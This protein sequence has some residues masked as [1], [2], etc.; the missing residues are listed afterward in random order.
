MRPFSI[1]K[2]LPFFFFL[3]I[4][5]PPRSTLF[6]Y[7]TLFRSHQFCGSAHCGL[8]GPSVV[9]RAPRRTLTPHRN[10]VRDCLLGVLPRGCPVSLALRRSELCQ[11]AAFRF[12]A[13]GR[14]L[15]A[16]RQRGAFL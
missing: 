5:R 3:M 8:Q 7:T 1:R 16:F 12:A 9:A 13:G 15:S 6:P 2:S 4:R 14:T 10:L 11:S